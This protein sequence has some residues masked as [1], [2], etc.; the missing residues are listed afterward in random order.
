IEQGKY[1]AVI[2]N[3]ELL[4]LRPEKTEQILRSND[5]PDIRL[6]VRGLVFPAGS[7]R[8]LAFLIVNDY[9]DWNLLTE[10]AQPPKPKKFLVFFDNTKETEHA[11]KY[12]RGLLPKSLHDKVKYFHSTMTNAYRE[13]ELEEIKKSNTWGLCVT[14]AFGMGMDLPD[15]EIVVQWK[16]TCDLCTLWQRF[17]RAARGQGQTATAILLVEPKDLDNERRTKATRAK[18]RLPQKREGI[19]KKRKTTAH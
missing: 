17:G 4:I 8:D 11:T 14:D 13:E 9:S 3:P 1:H 10:A 16:A 6:M 2:I 12:L 19:G 15:V 5:R 18:L 7:Y